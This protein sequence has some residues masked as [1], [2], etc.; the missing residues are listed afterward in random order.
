MGR[1]ETGFDDTV[2]L[3]TGGGSGIGRATCE[4]LAAAGA[5]VAVADLD[6]DGARTVADKIAGHAIELD[7]SSAENWAT[8]VAEVELEHGGLDLA[9][10][11][12][13]VT[14]F[15]GAADDLSGAFQIENVT[16]TQYRR[17]MG[18]NVDGVILGTRACAPAIA[19]SEGGA[20]IATSSAAGVIAFPP[21]PIYTATKHAVVGFV[22]AMTPWL[23][24]QD[25]GCHAI[26][27]GAVDTNILQRNVAEEARAHG[28]EMMDPS[29]IAEAVLDAAQAPET[30]G[31]WLCLPG[32]D[33]FRY[34]FNPVFEVGVPN[35]DEDASAD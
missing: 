13:G 30:G 1:F 18:A 24:A 15:S 28:V 8:A 23:N 5:R 31:L 7:V 16:E 34:E 21:D 22:R 26:L 4:R 12:A 10:L 17:I 20:I 32:R 35:L 27:P 14:T 29:Q 19:D 6:F 3:V 11:N 33:P 25:I 9:F 2:A